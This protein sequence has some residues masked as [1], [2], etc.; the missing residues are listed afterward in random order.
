MAAMARMADTEAPAPTEELARL[1]A[2]ILGA[3][4]GAARA[5]DLD[6]AVRAAGQVA[7]ERLEP[8][9][10]AARLRAAAPGDPARRAFVEALTISETYFFRIGGQFEAL[11]ERVLPALIVGRR[12]TRRLRLWSAGC[13]TGEEAW[14]LAILLERLAPPG[15]DA[16]VLAT[17]VDESALEQA[18]RGVYGQRSFR[19]TPAWVQARWLTARAD[20]WEVDPRLRRRVRF[21]PLN[22]ATDA[23]PSKESGT[24]G[25]DLLLCRNVLIYF[26]PEA[27]A[28]AAARLARCLAPGGWLAVAPAEL[29]SAAFPDL[30]VRHFPSAILYQRPGAAAAPAAGG[31][32]APPTARPRRAVTL[33]APASPA[34]ATVRATPGDSVDRAAAAVQRAAERLAEARAAADRGDRAEAGRL[35]DGALEVDPLLAPARELR[36]QLLL[37]DGD[38]E[39]AE[40]ELRAALFLD[41]ALA[42]AH[43]TLGA[44]LARRGERSRAAAAAAEVRRLLAGRAPGEPVPGGGGVTVGRLLADLGTWDPR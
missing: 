14:T 26:T 15:W 42:V 28:R 37:D 22:L 10:L 34:A 11:A 20:G 23:Y 27:R 32:A 25:I 35:V 3:D 1:A 16:T 18:R 31:A 5:A 44:L 6:R 19:L 39:A 33:A 2:E 17:D 36:A 13:S 7:G 8:D 12:R 43:A 30:A 24:S 41:P 21:A 29:S 40:G 9:A 4:V 38:D